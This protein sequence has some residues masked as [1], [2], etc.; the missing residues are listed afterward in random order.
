MASCFNNT[1]IKF[2]KDPP[3]FNAN[4]LLWFHSCLMRQSVVFY[5]RI[6]VTVWQA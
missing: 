5:Y 2:Y 6:S 4:V 3:F 1:A